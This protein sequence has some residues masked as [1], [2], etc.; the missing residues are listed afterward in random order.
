MTS[1][2]MHSIAVQEFLD[3]IS[4]QHQTGGDGRTKTIVRRIVSDLFRTIEELDVTPKEFWA[5]IDWLNTAG[6]QGEFGLIAPGLGFEHL[7]DV[8]MDEAD[9][10]AGRVGGTPRTIEGPLYVAGAPLSKGEARLDS[11]AQ[12][13]APLFMEGRV[14]D[15]DS[16]PVR[17][18]IV[19]VW[20]AD[21]KGG[22]SFF[23][24]GQPPYNLRRRI[25]TDADGRYAFRSIVPAGYGCPPGGAT[26]TLLDRLGRHGQRPAH[27]H[28][29]IS[30]P[31]CRHLTT[32][33]NLSDDA[34]LHDDFA[35][36]TRE[37]LIVDVVRRDRPED[38]AVRGVA[39]PF[40]EATFDF[41]L[42]P[43]RSGE[44]E[45]GSVRQRLE[46]ASN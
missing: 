21:Q 24:P 8:L 27:I 31:G 6:K 33:V 1:D 43:A 45:Q 46:P 4:G 15:L 18:A 2:Y 9:E 23:D 16:R 3:E 25:R 36:A 30:A 35:Y 26:L 19:D 28:F 34:Y 12:A 41:R 13:A 29:F 40:Y 39:E 42:Q 38:L 17:G 11:G 5:A 14:L 7:L 10:H 44:D 37:H 20:H 32:Q 22:Y